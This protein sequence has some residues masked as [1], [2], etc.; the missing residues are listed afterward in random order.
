[1]TWRVMMVAM[2]A[3]AA[4]LLA[5]G[6]VEQGEEVVAPVSGEMDAMAGSPST[7]GIDYEAEHDSPEPPGSRIE[8]FR[9]LESF[10]A[11]FD[12]VS[13]VGFQ[14]LPDPG[15]SCPEGYEIELPNPLE[16]GGIIFTGN[17]FLGSDG[18]LF[19]GYSPNIVYSDGHYH[20]T[21]LNGTIEPPP[22][23]EG[24]MLALEGMGEGPVAFI[25]ETAD[26]TTLR[27][28][29]TTAIWE[30]TYLGFRSPGYI[31]RL[32]YVWAGAHPAFATSGFWLTSG[33]P[34]APAAADIEPDR[35]SEDERKE[36]RVIQNMKLIANTFEQFAD[37]NGGVYPTHEASAL[38]D[39]TILKELF[40]GRQ[41]PINPFSGTPT[42]FKWDTAPSAA[43]GE[44]AAT[45]A[46]T[47]FYEIRGRGADAS[48][49]LDIVFTSD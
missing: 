28:G 45:T 34:I 48:S 2:M 38:P 13:F 46:H 19:S 10:E 31:Q 32:T 25:V 29:A 9:D 40:P 44:I 23:T 36:W 16:I 3:I 15:S 4:G 6:C 20:G 41:Y 39:G 8:V 30:V 24:F 5:S 12:S 49:Y 1:M 22:G 47:D 37:L 7:A 11:V 35:I 26:G 43:P 17:S 14:E 27:A 21:S 42:N 33:I 18:C